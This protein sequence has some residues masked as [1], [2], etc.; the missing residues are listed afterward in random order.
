MSGRSGDH[1]PIEWIKLDYLVRDDDVQRPL[2]ERRAEQIAANFDPDAFGIMT[3]SERAKDRYVLIDGQH[4]AQALRILGWNGQTLPCQVFR[5]LSKADEASRFLGRNNFRALRFIDRFLIRLT[6]QD[7]TANAIARIASDAGYRIEAAGR[8]GSI[9]AAKA[10]EDV[11]LGKGQ[12][13]KGKNPE[14]LRDTLHVVTSAWD[15][16]SAAVN[17]K[18]ILG[19]GAFFLRYGDAIDRARLAKKL[20]GINSGPTG[21]IARGSGKQEMHGGS[22][23]C[24]IAH[25]LTEE[26]NRGLRGKKRLAG[27]RDAEPES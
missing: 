5:G 19:V 3:V 25:F 17:G 18:V 7:P 23:A 27:W 24:G 15:R 9:T 4:R 13:I 6:A 22:I 2:D 16:T 11:Y 10:L 12:R 21:L 8:D 20:A 14:V 1:A 26:Y